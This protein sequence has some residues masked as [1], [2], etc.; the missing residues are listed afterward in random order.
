MLPYGRKGRDNTRIANYLL[1]THNIA[2]GYPPSDK[3]INYEFKS[4]NYFENIKFKE[5]KVFTWNKF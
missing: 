5:I 3:K 4:I 2:T 1:S